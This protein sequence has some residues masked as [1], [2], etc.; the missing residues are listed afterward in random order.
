MLKLLANATR[1]SSLELDHHLELV[2]RLVE[3]LRRVTGTH[4]EDCSHLQ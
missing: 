2:A 1:S 4:M 3:G